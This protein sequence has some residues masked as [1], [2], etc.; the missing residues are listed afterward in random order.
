MISIQEDLKTPDKI[1]LRG[2]GQGASRKPGSPG[3]RHGTD[4]L[5]QDATRGAYGRRTEEIDRI[6]SLSTYPWTPR[7]KRNVRITHHR[8]LSQ[9]Q[10]GKP[11]KQIRELRSQ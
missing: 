6:K 11:S 2:F 10:G 8:K 5:V 4:R 9:G 1:G 7:S 3:L